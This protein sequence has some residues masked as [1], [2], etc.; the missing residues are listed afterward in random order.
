MS[1]V[2]GALASLALAVLCNSDLG[3][4]WSSP[5]RFGTA[6]VLFAA[7]AGDA[8]SLPPE[9]TILTM[10][11]TLPAIA[12]VVWLGN[13][14]AELV[15]GWSHAPLRAQT[16]PAAHHHRAALREAYFHEL[17]GSSQ[18]P[19]APAQ[20]SG[21]E[22]PLEPEA[23]DIESELRDLLAERLRREQTAGAAQAAA[24]IE[25]PWWIILDL[26]PNAPMTDITSRYRSKLK[27]YH[28]DRVSGL[29]PEL[30]AL[31]EARTKE[32]NRAFD[33]AKREAA[34]PA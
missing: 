29:A 10:M 18:A 15:A 12:S 31:A 11:L 30:V 24:S 6:V 22:P 4:R 23:I 20:P 1:I 16:S 9:D 33:E 28:P 26:A 2:A 3:P 19:I 5:A 8:L 7:A 21:D 17:V 27:Q 25:A 34:A 32:L 13:G 14:V